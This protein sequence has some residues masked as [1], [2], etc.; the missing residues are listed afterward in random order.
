[1]NNHPSH[2]LEMLR[3]LSLQQKRKEN[4]G[5]NFTITQVVYVTAMINHI[6]IS[7][8]SVQIYGLSYIH[9]IFTIYGYITNH[10][11][12]SSQLA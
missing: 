8:F 1:M 7:F 12:A 10:K 5:L 4:S 11:V 2:V 3:N 6:F 9:C